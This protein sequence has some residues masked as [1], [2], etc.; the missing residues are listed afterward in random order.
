MRNRPGIAC[1]GTPPGLLHDLR[2]H[3]DQQWET[4]QD[5]A[6]LRSFHGCE[7][8]RAKPDIKQKKDHGCANR[9]M[10]PEPPGTREAERDVNSI[11]EKQPDRDSLVYRVYFLYLRKR[12]GI[13]GIAKQLDAKLEPDAC[14]SL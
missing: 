4:H 12:K 11:Q 3:G 14:S 6:R 1:L 5:I 10:S 7:K 2:G 8:R 9:R 13:P